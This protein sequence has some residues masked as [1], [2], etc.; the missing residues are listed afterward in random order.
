[1]SYS[2]LVLEGAKLVHRDWLLVGTDT[3]IGIR[4]VARDIWEKV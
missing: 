2:V 4:S 3:S 1:M